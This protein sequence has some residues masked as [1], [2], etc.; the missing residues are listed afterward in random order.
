[1]SFTEDTLITRITNGSRSIDFLSN[2]KSISVNNGN[3]TTRMPISA[4]I[5]EMLNRFNN[6]FEECVYSYRGRLYSIC[7]NPFGCYNFY[8]EVTRETF[9]K[10][11]DVDQCATSMYKVKELV[12]GDFGHY[13]DIFLA[14]MWNLG[15]RRD[16]TFKNFEYVVKTCR[17]IIDYALERGE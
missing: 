1:M 16:A 10:A 2:E 13:D 6:I 14:D 4:V 7:V 11:C 17:S 15:S 9:N 8:V 3:T 5:R 12:G